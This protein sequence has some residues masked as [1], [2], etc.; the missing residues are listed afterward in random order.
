M[1]LSRRNPQLFPQTTD[2]KA[3]GNPG[4]GA[5][6]SRGKNVFVFDKDCPHLS[7]QTGRAPGNEMGD[8]HEIFIPAGTGHASAPLDKVF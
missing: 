4:R 8:F 3:V 2:I 1:A 6:I 5:V 7:A